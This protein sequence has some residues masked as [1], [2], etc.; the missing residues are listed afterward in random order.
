MLFVLLANA[1]GHFCW[2][3]KIQKWFGL[4]NKVSAQIPRGSKGPWLSP[5][6]G[7]K[8]PWAQPR[9]ARAGDVIRNEKIWNSSIWL[10]KMGVGWRCS[11]K[12][13]LDI[14]VIQERFWRP[15]K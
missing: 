15:F 11:A 14:F 4:T 13:V 9:A 12:P 1:L 5:P 6:K 2:T 7:P 8:G 10:S 3:L